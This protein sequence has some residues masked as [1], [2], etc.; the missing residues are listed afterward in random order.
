MPP[1]AKGPTRPKAAVKPAEPAKPKGA[2][3]PA[4]PAQPKET[5]Q[6]TPLWLRGAPLSKEELEKLEK[7]GKPYFDN[8]AAVAA[9]SQKWRNMGLPATPKQYAEEF[10]DSAREMIRSLREHRMEPF[11]HD[12]DAA[13][14]SSCT[15]YK[16]QIMNN[17]LRYGTPP[18]EHL[19]QGYRRNIVKMAMQ[20]A[21]LGTAHAVLYRC[22]D[23]TPMPALRNLCAWVDKVTKAKGAID[24]QRYQGEKSFW[25]EGFASGSTQESGARRFLTG[26]KGGVLLVITPR[27]GCRGYVPKSKFRGE[28]ELVLAPR[29]Q[30]IIESVSV[31]SE[32]KSSLTYYRVGVT[33]RR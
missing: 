3:K 12:A 15:S 29:T 16:Y 21:P 25:E 14:T 7:D 30:F 33:A 18:P 27:P 24:L 28:H 31:V 1:K 11:F 26:K 8:L 10:P 32:E 2:V 13:Y 23:Q 4:G 17:M 19:E 6:R 22:V 5:A 9:S 20:M